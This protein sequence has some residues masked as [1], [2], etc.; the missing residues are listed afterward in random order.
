MKDYKS[1]TLAQLKLEF[2]GRGIGHFASY[3]LK[4]KSDFLRAFAE[5]DEA[6]SMSEAELLD[7]IAANQ[8]PMATKMA[9]RKRVMEATCEG[10]RVWAKMNPHIVISANTPD[11]ILSERRN[12]VNQYI[13]QNVPAAICK[14]AV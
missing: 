14:A 10:D 5:A 13:F 1:M 3:G 6:E 7:A 12:F 4:R 2:L 8:K 9:A 11:G